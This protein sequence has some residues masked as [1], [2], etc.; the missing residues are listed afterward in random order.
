MTRRLLSLARDSRFLLAGTV[1][2][3]LLA[4]WL[5][6]WQALNLSQLIDRV[7]L[8][9]QNGQDVAGLL[10]F[11]L[12]IVFMRAGLAWVSEVSANA[13]A[14]TNQEWTAPAAV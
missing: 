11:L 14:V 5:T 10:R 8:G 6:I 9:G 7:F 1:L 12:L 2:C 3:G 13:M 4:G